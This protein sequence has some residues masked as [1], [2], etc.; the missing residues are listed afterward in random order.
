MVREWSWSLK[1]G[2]KVDGMVGKGQTISSE[3]ALVVLLIHKNSLRFVHE[4]HR[5]CIALNTNWSMISIQ[6]N[7]WNHKNINSIVI[8]SLKKANRIVLFHISGNNFI[9]DRV[10]FWTLF[11][12]IHVAQVKVT[13]LQQWEPWL[14]MKSSDWN[15]QYLYHYPLLFR[16]FY[17]SIQLQSLALS[18]RHLTNLIRTIE[19]MNPW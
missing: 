3:W 15:G 1:E 13:N 19:L 9:V 16:P 6:M 18:F 4:N 7:L 14:L 12:Y 10:S 11:M 2:R 5:I 17:L 8:R